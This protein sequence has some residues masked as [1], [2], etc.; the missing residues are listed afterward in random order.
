MKNI[1]KFVMPKRR[2]SILAASMPKGLVFLNWIAR[3]D[4]ENC[5]PQII[6]QLAKRLGLPH[7]NISNY[8]ERHDF[9]LVAI[10]RVHGYDCNKA[11]ALM[12][13]LLYLGNYYELKKFRAEE[14]YS[15]ELSDIADQLW[16]DADEKTKKLVKEDVKR[17]KKKDIK[18][19]DSKA[20][21]MS[22]CIQTIECG[23]LLKVYQWFT[24]NYYKVGQFCHDS[25]T[26]E[27]DRYCPHPDPLPEDVID[28]VNKAI[29]EIGSQI[30]ES[31]KSTKR[32]FVELEIGGQLHSTDPDLHIWCVPLTV[33]DVV[34]QST[35][36]MLELILNEFQQIN[37]IQNDV[38]PVSAF[39]CA[40]SSFSCI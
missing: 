10:N 7:D 24:D 34:S 23:I 32:S 28:E 25:L 18:L 20:T 15:K 4:M 37:E 33:K 29:N 40:Q 9:W 2:A 19:K 3:L 38:W 1:A 17:K 13:R 36:K 12:L 35:E 26:I 11:K 39:S 30:H 14:K 27:H 6:K 31:T 22:W 5:H 8:I 21:L 16:E